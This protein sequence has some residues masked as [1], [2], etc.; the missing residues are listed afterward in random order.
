LR[1]FDKGSVI[2]GPCLR[3]AQGGQDLIPAEQSMPVP[4]PISGW[5]QME[6][7]VEELARL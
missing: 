6:S 7:S 3:I 1:K 5:Q 2:P 4:I